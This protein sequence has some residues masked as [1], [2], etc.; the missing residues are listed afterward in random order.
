MHGAAL[1]RLVA[2]VADDGELIAERRERLEDRAQLEVA[3]GRRRRPLLHDRAVREVE[4]PQP[5]LRRRRGVRERGGRGNHRIEQRQRRPRR[6]RRAERCGGKV[7][8]GDEHA[9]L[10]RDLGAGRRCVCSS[11]ASARQPSHPERVARRRC[12]GR[13]TRSDSPRAAA[14]RTIARTAGMSW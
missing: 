1:A 5:R 11:R 13:A 2:D 7:L 4:E 10:P 9:A 6:P 12:L 14:W 3:A 8:L